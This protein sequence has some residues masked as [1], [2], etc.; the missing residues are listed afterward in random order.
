MEEVILKE[1]ELLVKGLAHFDVLASR[2]SLRFLPVDLSWNWLDT[3]SSD[4]LVEFKLP[5]GTYATSLFREIC[6]TG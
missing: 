1:F 5:R 4:L 3:D 6:L 2:R